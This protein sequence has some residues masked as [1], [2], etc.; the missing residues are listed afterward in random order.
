M[1]TQELNVADKDWNAARARLLAQDS[2]PYLI[3]FALFFVLWLAL[4]V[5]SDAEVPGDNYEQL[6]W[7]LTPALGYVKHPPF[8]TW[9]LWIFEQVFP[10]GVMLTYVLGALQVAFL[11]TIVW[12][13]GCEVLDR[14]RALTGVLFVSCITYYTNRMHF[15]NHNTALLVATVAAVYVLW[16]AVQS[17]AIK[18]WLLLGVC[19]GI[20]ILCKYQMAVTIVCNGIYVLSLGRRQWRALLPGVV[21]AAIVAGLVVLPHVIWLVQNHF[22]T[23]AYASKS[24]AAHAHW[25]DRPVRELKFLADQSLRLVNL[26]VVMIALMFL[27][28]RQESPP[29]APEVRDRR[30]LAIHAFGPLV[31]MT[32]LS[33]FFGVE[34]QMH[35][36]TAFLWAVPLWIVSTSWGGKVARLHDKLVLGCVACA[37]VVM[38][39]GYLLRL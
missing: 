35:W 28:R 6:T 9:I 29:V 3:F 25:S 31:F 32:L 36:G 2:L 7:A 5:L 33:M 23:F 15:Y 17:N 1:N 30:F 11:L 21:F 10:A 8:P 13:I 20:G 39:A 14:R 19:W 37:Q 24:L 12:L 27:M 22:P 16:R 26:L 4:P 38:A 18:W 34:L